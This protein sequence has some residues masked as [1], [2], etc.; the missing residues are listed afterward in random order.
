MQYKFFANYNNIT[1]FII[2]LQNAV[3]KLK[4]FTLLFEVYKI[5]I[6]WPSNLKYR[7]RNFFSH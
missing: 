5:F 6:K 4:Y 1:D 7:R 3:G 2:L